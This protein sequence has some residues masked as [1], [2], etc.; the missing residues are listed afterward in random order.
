MRQKKR[1]EKIMDS[2]SGTPKH[3]TIFDHHVVRPLCT[4]ELVRGHAATH[5]HCSRRYMRPTGLQLDKVGQSISSNTKRQNGSPNH[6]PNRLRSSR[7][8]HHQGQ[9]ESSQLQALSGA[10]QTQHPKGEHF[11]WN[12]QLRG[13][14]HTAIMRVGDKRYRAS[15]NGA[16]GPLEG[17]RR[18]GQA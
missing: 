11:P 10:I 7:H 4:P 12:Y 9:Q 18:G 14:H 8:W 1:P 2:K 16:K 13:S 5:E 15:V 17:R 3:Q 6:N